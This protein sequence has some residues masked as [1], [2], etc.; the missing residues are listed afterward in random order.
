MII[1]KCIYLQSPRGAKRGNVWAIIVSISHLNYD[2][3][4]AF[5]PAIRY[6]SAI[7]A[8]SEC[9]HVVI[10]TLSDFQTD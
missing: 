6:R 4:K 7:G 10:R 8:R 3:H 5:I 1:G 9:G 2:D